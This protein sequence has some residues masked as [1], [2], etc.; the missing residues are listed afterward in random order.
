MMEPNA[1]RIGKNAMN[2]ER[3]ITLKDISKSTNLS[4]LTK[5]IDLSANVEKG[6]YSDLSRFF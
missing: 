2:T 4:T 6:K 1:V 5:Q 3:N